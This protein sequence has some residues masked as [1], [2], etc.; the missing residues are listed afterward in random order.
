VNDRVTPRCEP[1]QVVTAV[2][3]RVF[4]YGVFA[5]LTDGTPAYVRQRE[6]TLAGNIDPQQ[7]VSE[8]QEFRAAVLALPQAGR[9]LELSIRRAEPDPWE[10][11]VRQYRVK[12][13]VTGT[14]KWISSRGV[15]IEI[16]PGVDGFIPAHELAPWSVD[17]PADLLWIGDQVEAMITHLDRKNKRVQLSIRQQMLHLVRVQEFVQHLQAEPALDEPS[18]EMEQVEVDVRVVVDLKPL[19]RVLVLDDDP[20]VR[21]TLTV[22]LR[23]HGCQADQVGN[24]EEGL[25]HLHHAEYGVAL[26]DLDLAGHD[27]IE[28]IRALCQSH[29]DMHVLVM[30]IPE[31][32]AE[33]SQELESLQVTGVFVK[34]LNPDEVLDT[35]ARLAEGE[36]VGPFRATAFG[37]GHEAAEPFQQV[38]ST[39]RSGIPLEDRLEAGVADLVRLTRAEQGVLF[40]LDPV[41]QQGSIAALAGVLSVNYEGV[42]VLA[43]SPVKDVIVNRNEVF[44]PRLTAQVRLRFQ[45]LLDVVAFGSCVGV[46]VAALGNVEHALFLFHRE[47]EAF[48][49]YRLRDAQAMAILLGAALENEA[50]EQRIQSTNPFL[51]SGQLA[52]GFGHDVFNKMSALEFQ[53]RNL[54]TRC[55]QMV[56]ETD[57]QAA[58]GAFDYAEAAQDLDRLFQTT[59]DLRKTVEAF[60]ELIRAENQTAIDVNQVVQQAALLLQLTSEGRQVHLE[61]KPAPG[62][63]LVVGN[64]VRLQQVFLNLML[65]ATQH[66][67]EQQKRWPY[68]LALL[69]VT[70]GIDSNAE[71]PVWIRFTDTGPGIHCRLWED[72]FALGFSTRPKGTGLGLFIARSLVESMGGAIRVEQSYIPLGTTFRVELPAAGSES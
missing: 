21:E 4:S 65:N 19:R 3:E 33:R 11:F 28:F 56:Q 53:V 44:E 36:M 38:A 46:P 32:I 45:K 66:T 49:R 7:V 17:Q 72:I 27:G 52:A 58:P 12:H 2:V 64:P 14:V 42:R 29:L 41:S 51:L 40:H 13:T 8:G 59:L 16:I 20:A 9:R 55:G 43:A 67:I 71:R 15:F 54:R 18:P 6:L 24:S 35:L 50:V 1:G 61:I 68:G 34:P 26:V 10:A 69:Q 37:Q 23:N 62:L 63:P 22:W 60:R 57:E 70:V 25:A 30:S 48:S 31:W 39:V 47:P 5:H